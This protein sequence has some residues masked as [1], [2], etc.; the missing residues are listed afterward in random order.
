MFIKTFWIMFGDLECA[1]VQPVVDTRAGVVDTRA[2][3]V[4]QS[5]SWIRAGRGS[6]TLKTWGG[7][8]LNP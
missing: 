1:S 4:D 2:L 7:V 6:A 5:R 3:I 8:F